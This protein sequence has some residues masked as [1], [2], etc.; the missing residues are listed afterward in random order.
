MRKIRYRLFLMCAALISTGLIQAQETEV[1]ESA[2]ALE[3]THDEAKA[4]VGQWAVE[5]GFWLDEIPW[6]VFEVSWPIDWGQ[7][8]ELISNET[9]SPLDQ[10]TL[11]SRQRDLLLS[12]GEEGA[13]N[14]EHTGSGAQWSAPLMRWNQPL[15][16]FERLISLDCAFGRFPGGAVEPL[17]A[18]TSR[19][20]EWPESS[21]LDSGE[22]LRITTGSDGLYKIDRNWISDAGFDPDTLDPGKMNLYG[23]GGRLLPMDNSQSRPLGL[24]VASIWFEGDEN[25]QW[26]EGEFFV[27]WANGP[28]AIQRDNAGIGWLHDRHAYEDVAHYFLRLD[29]SVDPVR[30]DD[31]SPIAE[32][33]DTLINRYWNVQ[34]H[35]QE[36][37]SPNRSGREW[38]GE[39]FGVVNA[40]TFNFATPYATERPGKVHVRVAVQSMGVSSPFELT[41]GQVQLQASPSYTSATSTSNVANLATAAGAGSIASA[42]GL[43]AENAGVSVNLVFQPSVSE[44]VGWLD[45]IRVEQECHLKFSGNA[46]HFQSQEF[47]LGILEYSMNGADESTRLWDIT[48]PTEPVELPTEWTDGVTSWKSNSDTLSRFVAFRGQNFPAPVFQGVAAPTNLHAVERADLV[49]VTRPAFLEAAQRLANL[50][51]DEGL[52]VLLT[53]QRA[54]FDE[55]SS[56]SVD[57]TAIKM[58]MMM[59]R[60]RALENDW[61]P[62]RYLQLFGDGTFANRSNLE[63]SPY[64]IT[65]QSE[66]SLSPTGSYVS[67]D[68]FGFL[69]DQ[70]GEGIGDKLAI[71]VGRIPCGTASEAE[72]MVDKIEAYMKSPRADAEPAGCLNDDI[73]NNDGTWR[74]VI[75]LVSDDMDGNGGPTEIEHMV[76]SDEHADKIAEDHPQYDV[77]KI[78]M[79]AYPQESTPG[80]E[81]YP[82]AQVAVDRQVQEGALIVNYI[83]HGGERGWSHERLLNTTTIQDWQNFDQMPLFMT[84]TCEL[85]RFDDPEVESAGEM[86]VLNPRGGAIAMLTTTRV[87]FSGSN[88]QLNRA[89]YEIALE[90][91]GETPLRLGDIVRVTKNDPQVSNSSNKRNF[92]LLGDVALRLNYPREEIR[93]TE[94]PDTLKALDLA[95]IRGFVSNEAGDVLP[96]FNGIV[97]VKV[98]DKRS[99]ITTLNNDGAP[100][101]HTFQVFRNVLFS[102]VASVESGEFEFSFVVPRDIDYN[103]GNGRIS[104]YAVSDSTDA[105]GASES[106]IIG[107]VSNEFSVDDEAPIVQLYINDTSFVSG[108]LTSENP[109][110]LARIFDEGGINASGVG[111][112]HDIKA[113]LDGQS[114]ESIVL[115]DFYTTDLNTYQKGTVRYPF[116]S[117]EAGRHTLDL[118]VWDVQNNKGEAVLEFVVASDANAALGHVLAYPN[119]SVE[120]F[121]FS[122]EH[123]Q[124]CQNGELVLEVFSSKGQQVH[125]Q[126]LPWHE[127][128]FRATNLRWEPKVPAGV[129]VFR[130]TL[131]PENGTPVQYSNQLVVL[132]P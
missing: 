97:H 42:S 47:G 35:E 115:N 14:M 21:P 93:F 27:F 36:L 58:L 59:L 65:Y 56:G 2:F 117:L 119:P 89:F 5:G 72:E 53:T 113:T 62:P 132:R 19:N 99:Q 95:L 4:P 104:A 124:A 52:S 33:P 30:V 130:L 44:A 50:H 90:D 15:S 111:I 54:V 87:V 64:V 110:L 106:L 57:P 68:Y 71:G 73:G 32:L 16:Q 88:Q 121:Q 96:D 114:D 23:N 20:R 26:D 60:D 40:R 39:S 128:G 3:W 85:A 18:F 51:A 43:D 94:V 34:F 8:Q 102:G 9:W 112:G 105:H 76:H 69:E 108:G 129:Y 12:E 55:F 84:A 28:H 22:F 122:I 123:N 82:D 24:Q 7:G 80:G 38:F 29:D 81:R 131:L 70:Y 101:P 41:A 116:E 74:N 127:E 100:N 126:S 125:Y 77:T 79:D 25:G 31:G 17:P 37:E 107:G 66:N 49:I 6:G 103:F 10:N 48:D 1:V 91:T 86:M 67:D 118:V 75:C 78:Y 45:Y 83:G 109:W 61:K 98:F 92:S 46:L 120:G 11:T 13:W 63:S